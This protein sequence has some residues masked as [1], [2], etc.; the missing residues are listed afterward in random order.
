[1]E[2]KATYEELKMRTIAFDTED[3]IVTSDKNGLPDVA[4]PD[5]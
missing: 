1:M 3:V 4:D 5:A 2:H